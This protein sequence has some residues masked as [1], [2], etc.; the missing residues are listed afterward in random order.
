MR[1]ELDVD[2]TPIVFYSLLAH[3]DIPA[4]GEGTTP[5]PWVE[6]LA[7]GS[8]TTAAA[9]AAGKVV[10]IDERV[11]AG[12]PVGAVGMV[13]RGPEV[14]PEVHFEIFTTE[15]LP[16]DLGRSFRTINAADDGPIARRADIVAAIDANNDQQIDQGE[17]WRFFRSGELD[18]RQGLRKL[19]IRHRHEWGDKNTAADLTGLRELAGL[20]ESDRRAIYDAAFARYVFWTDGLSRATGLPT[21]QV[22]YSYHP[23]TFLLEIASRAA[24]VEMPKA[25]GREVGDRALEPRKLAYVPVREWTR[26]PASAIEP[27]L[28]GPPVGVRL[29]A[30]RREDIPLIE[31]PST[32]S[33]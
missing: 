1:H 8:P 12:D 11:E 7:H 24:H 33:R 23:L 3:I 30:R 16:G 31:L 13:S 2:E 25:R 4:V 18:R 28:F 26:P 14:G 19:A 22:V 20:P 21:N 17:L 29:E 5:V 10:V 15:R 32:D 6:A 9:L 27:P